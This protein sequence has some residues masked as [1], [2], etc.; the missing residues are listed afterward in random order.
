MSDNNCHREEMKGNGEMNFDIEIATRIKHLLENKVTQSCVIEQEE[1]VEKIAEELGIN[2]EE[3]L[4]CAEK[5]G[6]F[7]SYE[8]KGILEPTV[9]LLR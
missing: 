2:Q 5:C 1:T 7:W 4:D 8:V 6:N 9:R 3:V